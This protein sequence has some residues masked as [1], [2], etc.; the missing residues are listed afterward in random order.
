MG[1]LEGIR[2]EKLKGQQQ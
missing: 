2:G 1:Q